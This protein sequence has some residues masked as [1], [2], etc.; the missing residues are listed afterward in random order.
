MTKKDISRGMNNDVTS[1]ITTFLNRLGRG[2]TWQYYWTAETK[3]TLWFPVGD[4]PV[5]PE[6]KS[7]YFGVHPQ[8]INLGSRERGKLDGVDVINHLYAEFDTKD[9]WSADQVYALDPRPSIIIFSG[10]GW[11]CYWLLNETIEVNDR[12]RADLVKLQHAWVE[13]MGGDGGAK[14]LARVL[15]VPYSYNNK[16]QYEHPM[17]VVPVEANYDLEYRMADL[18][19]LVRPIL[20]KKAAALSVNVDVTS[21]P[22]LQMKVLE[23]LGKVKKERFENYEDWLHIG[24]ALHAGFKGSQA[25]L[26]MWDIASRNAPEKYT[27]GL[28]AKKWESFNID[29]KEGITINTLFHMAEEDSDGTFV[30]PGKK[31]AKPSEYMD[32]VH[33]MGYR[34]TKNEM[35]E[36]IYVN[37][38]LMS[39]GLESLIMTRLREHG[40]KGKDVFQDAFIAEAEENSFHPIRNYLENLE[41]DGVD[42]FTMIEQYM[43]DEHGL[44]GTLIRKFMI[45]AVS[46]NLTPSF[47]AMMKDQNPM[48]VLVGGQKL[49]KSV[50]SAWLGSVLPELYTKGPIRPD[51]KDSQIMAVSSFIHEVDELNGTISRADRERLK[52]YLNNPW[53]TFRPPYGKHEI[54]KP[55]TVS[56]IGTVNS[57][58]SGFLDD[59]TGN[60]RYR[61]VHLTWMD[62]HTDED[63][64]RHYG[65]EENI[66]INQ[67]WAQAVHLFRS[68]ESYEL[69]GETEKLVEEVNNEYSRE[70]ALQHY[71][72]ELFGVDKSNES[73]F[74]PSSDVLKRLKI[75]GYIKD[76]TDNYTSKRVAGILT[77]MGAEGTRKRTDGKM[78]RGW[79]FV[80]PVHSDEEVRLMVAMKGMT[81]V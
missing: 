15:R 51:D 3:E 63:G 61:V 1:Q 57:D 52:G 10:G 24:M 12:N 72:E 66:D 19:E 8:K 76:D 41:W 74:V 43:Q 45:G 78:V 23:A 40:Y 68:G 25:G 35:N 32:A 75:F 28:C 21:D 80:A 29:R 55:T 39:T 42:R 81:P 71:V 64:K 4:M 73:A 14:D 38:T 54:K 17:Q 56:Y 46:R 7:V 50:F 5:L 62:Y 49:G 2:G 18:H 44:I 33:A 65:Y 6:W 48:L 30:N 53:H 16:P 9:G 26:S 37:G 36:R 34:F 31:G 77:K 69:D 11:H 70:D 60:R 22:S 13:H 58:G 27:P 47:M 20:E 67:L 59:P 79:K